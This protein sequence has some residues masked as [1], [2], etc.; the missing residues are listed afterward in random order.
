MLA[1]VSLLALVSAALAAPQSVKRADIDHDAVVGFDETVPDTTIGELMLK[2]KP[3]LY[4]V[5]GCVP[6]PA[7]DEDG[8]TSAGLAPSG[9]PSGDCD[10]STGQIYAR[11]ESYNDAFAIMYSW[12]W[13]KDEPSW[14]ESL[15]GVGHRYDW[16]DIVVW[17]SDDT[18]D[19]TLLGVAASYHGDYVT[20]TDP[21][22]SGDSPLIKYYTAYA[23]LDH[24]L[25]FTDTVGG[26]QPLIAWDSLP[27][28]AQEALADKDWGDANVPFIDANF[29]SNL[30]EA[31]L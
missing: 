9:D 16:E 18:S 25:G 23:I 27:T 5:D 24:S 29:E 20:S 10:S 17:L 28:V 14:L 4:V 22:L 13:P 11:A 19:A 15:V 1:K 8:N 31:E 6:F 30:A 7:V 21:D 3:T 12:Y 26:T 2:W